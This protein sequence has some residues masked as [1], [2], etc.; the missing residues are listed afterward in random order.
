VKA[1][2]A[3]AGFEGDDDKL[4]ILE[5]IVAVHD[6][7]EVWDLHEDEYLRSVAEAMGLPKEKYKDMTLDFSIEE[8]GTVLKPP[9]LPPPRKK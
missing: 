8:A 7:D 2:V 4:K 6:S 9:P 3:G 1:A 5:L